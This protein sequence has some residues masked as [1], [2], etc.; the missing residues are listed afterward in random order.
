MSRRWHWVYHEFAA[1]D[2]RF[3]NSLEKV[4]S[5]SQSGGVLGY[6]ADFPRR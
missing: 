3:I 4:S 6:F 2:D 5:C 1:Y